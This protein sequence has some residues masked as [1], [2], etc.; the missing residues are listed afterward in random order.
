M[1]WESLFS[2]QW[3]RGVIYVI[4]LVSSWKHMLWVLVR[5]ASSRCFQWLPTTYVL[6]RNRK[7][8]STF[9]VGKSA[10]SGD[11]NPPATVA[12]SQIN[13]YCRKYYQSEKALID[14]YRCADW[15]D[16]GLYLL[17]VFCGPFS[18][19]IYPKYSD[20]LPPECTC[21]NS[22]TSPC[23]YLL[24]SKLLVDE[25]QTAYMPYLTLWDNISQNLA[26]LQPISKKNFK[27]HRIFRPS[28]RI[29]HEELIIN[30]TTLYFWYA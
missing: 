3:V 7:N 8:T 6:W 16:L 5:S 13:G 19:L 1:V 15:S 18:Y 27:S 29:F 14:L 11:M 28:K 21:P 12:D 17:P 10:L 9:L 2:L 20:T 24:M 22:W 25:W 30:Y 26:I 4:F 23:Y